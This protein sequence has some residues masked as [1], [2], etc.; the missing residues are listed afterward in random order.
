MT[1][2]SPFE[3]ALERRQPHTDPTERMILGEMESIS[4]DSSGSPLESYMGAD[5]VAL[6]Y[7]F[8]RAVGQQGIKG[9]TLK[10]E[11]ADHPLNAD[12][13][14]R[15]SGAIEAQRKTVK[16][17]LLRATG[18]YTL[19][20][21]LNNIEKKRARRAWHTVWQGEGFRIGQ[22]T[23]Q[24]LGNL[25]IGPFDTYLCTDGLLRCERNGNGF[26]D[27]IRSAG[28]GSIPEGLSVV[29]GRWIDDG[30][31]TNIAVFRTKSL[32]EILVDI[33]QRGTGK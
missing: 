17:V 28:V 20:R 29:F 10:L 21:P 15:G 33:Y 24:K 31:D 22:T 1:N 19:N 16:T 8:L 6:C 7:D 4:G 14:A 30:G 25:E 27:T 5:N 13:R 26:P 32:E 9:D 11:T 3:A 23:T 18:Q 12:E 2:P